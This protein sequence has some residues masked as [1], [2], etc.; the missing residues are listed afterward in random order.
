[1]N[2]L[3]DALPHIVQ[4]TIVTAAGVVLATQHIISGGEAIA[5]IA[6]ANGFTMGVTGA[7]SSISTA[8]SAAADVS[9]S[10]STLTS[11]HSQTSS[12]GSP[13]TATPTLTQST[14]GNTATIP[15]NPT[16]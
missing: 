7:S 8:A 5:L 4:A 13:E 9:H 16:G 6:A 3:Q 14:G 11:T 12:T 2:K 1:M 10:A 15:N